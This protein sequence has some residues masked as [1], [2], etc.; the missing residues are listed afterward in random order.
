V[1]GVV[2]GTIVAPVRLDVRAAV[3]GLVVGPDEVLV[4]RIARHLAPEELAAHCRVL[5]DALGRDRYIILMGEDW[6]MAKV[7]DPHRK[8]TSQPRPGEPRTIAG[9]AL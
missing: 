4:L 2:E 6:G 7:Y 3:D 9:V 1:D 5:E 8:P